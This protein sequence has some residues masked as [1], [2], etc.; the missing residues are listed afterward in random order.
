MTGPTWI[1]ETR[2]DGAYV[3]KV[4]KALS[5]AWTVLDIMAHVDQHAIANAI[6]RADLIDSAKLVL[7]NIEDLK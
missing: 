5:I 7:K 1:D 2:T 6:Q 3:D 4:E